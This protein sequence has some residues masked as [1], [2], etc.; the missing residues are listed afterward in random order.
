MKI[1]EPL[2]RVAITIGTA[3]GKHKTVDNYCLPSRAK[4]VGEEEA[5]MHSL[6]IVVHV[7][8]FGGLST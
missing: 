6:S 3:L 2:A 7:L 1:V 4:S 8:G 5:S